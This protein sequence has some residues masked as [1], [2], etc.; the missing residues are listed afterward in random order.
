MTRI[1]AAHL[2]ND[3]SGS[4]KVLSQLLKG[5]TAAGHEVHL[6]SSTSTPGFLSG[7][8]GISLHENYY[9]FFRFV[10]LRLVVLMASQFLTLL[11]LLIR[12]KRED[13]VYVNTILPFGAAIAGRI[14]GARVIYHI[15]E[16]SVNPLI[17]KNFLLFWVRCCAA[18]VVYVSD[19][20]ANEE[21]INKPSHILWNAIGDDFREQ[22]EAHRQH[23]WEGSNVLM[24]CSLK[25]YKGVDEYVKIARACA[26]LHFDLVVNASQQEIAAYFMGAALPANLTVYPAQSN[27]HPFYQRA[28]VVMNLSRPEEWKET[29]GLTALEGMVYGLPVIVPQ[30]G[31]IAEVVRDGQAGFHYNGKDTDFIVACLR[32]LKNKPAHYQAVSRRAAEEAARFSA[33]AF[34]ARSIRMIGRDISPDTG[35]NFHYL[36]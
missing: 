6:C 35:T 7:I 22:A 11:L 3:F 30:V 23:E 19:F 25:R 15:H 5:W 28:G 36:E 21:P 14:K 8:A 17:F 24:I 2:L 12:V 10:P 33:S 20:L 34:L 9:R 26:E 4:P 27:V 13:V 18:E 31:G 29:F 16:T 32:K 1:F